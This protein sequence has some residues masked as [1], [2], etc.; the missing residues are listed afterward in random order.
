MKIINLQAENIKRLVAVEIHPDGNMVQITGKNGAGKTSVLD[1]IWWALAGASNVTEEPIRKGKARA[2]ITLELGGEEVELIVTRTF[3]RQPPKPD[4]PEGKITTSVKVATPA[5]ATFPKAQNVLDEL[6]GSLSFDPLKFS[7]SN[8]K[9][10][11]DLLRPLV[12]DVDFDYI[13]GKNAADFEERRVL[14]KQA[15]E[16]RAQ[17]KSVALPEATALDPIDESKLVDAIERVHEVNADIDRQDRE[18]QALRESITEHLNRAEFY[19]VR[20]MELRDQIKSLEEE[21][22]D[23]ES[24]SAACH[25]KADSIEKHLD[26]LDP[27][28]DKADPAEVRAELSKAKE[29]NALV[30]A[31]QQYT[32][33]VA[34]AEVLEAE[35]EELTL[36]IESRNEEKAHAIAA[37]DLPV[38][39]LSFGSG[40]VELAGVPF[41][42]ASDAEQLR[43]SVAIAAALN[44][45]LR[46][47]RIRDGSLLDEDSLALVAKMAEERDMQI[48]I[49]R[50]DTSGEI[51]FVIEDGHV[52]G[53]EL[54]EAS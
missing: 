50:V 3:R 35:A 11:V 26:G 14:N 24:E 54:A 40:A 46:V 2:T 23:H 16:L 44:P 27:L 38:K 15:K 17:A 22:A 41:N 43:A 37:A 25:G 51:G 8:P 53:Q 18:R 20:V 45:K 47:I 12:P 1:S 19:D 42:Q 34:K 39:G 33:L 28:P 52:K 30:A 5:G 10:Q 32:N 21:I 48:W 29:H 9:E 49:E 13:D 7:R 36:A 4:Q 31:A 6:L